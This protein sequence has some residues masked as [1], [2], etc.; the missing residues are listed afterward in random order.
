MA[1][2]VQT[3]HSVFKKELIYLNRYETREQAKQSIFEYIEFFYNTRRIHFSIDY[4]TPT[5]YEQLHL[6]QAA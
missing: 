4:H 6:Y 2:D 1:E 5:E 3:L